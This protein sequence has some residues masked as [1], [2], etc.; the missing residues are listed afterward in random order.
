MEGEIAHGTW[1]DLTSEGES[2]AVYGARWISERPG[3]SERSVE[4]YSGL[5]RLHI[6]PGLGAK[7]IRKIMPADVRSW[8][9]G[10]IDGGTGA[11]TV[12]KAYR[13]LRAILNTLLILIA[14]FAS[15]RWG[16]LMVF[17][18]PTPTWSTAWSGSSAR[19]CSSGAEQVVK[20]P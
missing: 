10:L 2:L 16:E 18:G 5:L 9:Q 17:A 15:L 12:A 7:G 13:L 3:L 11:S 8:R 6:V 20:R 14:V 1:E 4:L 19:L